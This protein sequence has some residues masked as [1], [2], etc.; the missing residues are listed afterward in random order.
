MTFK[1]GSALAGV[2]ILVMVANV[3]ATIFYM[4]VY[5]HFINPGHPPQ[6]YQQHVQQAGPWCSIAAG[7]PLMFAAGWWVTGWRSNHPAVQS[8]GIVWAVYATLDLAVLLAAGMTASV[9]V[10]FV[11]SFSTKLAA[12]YAG[13]R[14]RLANARAKAA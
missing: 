9:A 2:A 11:L 14:L 6:Y 5:G 3:A 4:V 1:Q 10:L 12:V 8:G 7:I 13:S